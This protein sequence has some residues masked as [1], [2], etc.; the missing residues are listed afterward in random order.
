MFP[1]CYNSHI[2][3]ET[4]SNIRIY[5]FAR[6]HTRTHVFF[7]IHLKYLILL[8][9]RSDKMLVKTKW[10]L[11]IRDSCLKRLTHVTRFLFLSEQTNWRWIRKVIQTQICKSTF[12]SRWHEIERGITRVFCT[13]RKNP[14]NVNYYNCISTCKYTN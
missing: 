14:C 2:S 10:F 11:M 8:L 6:I 3:T 13:F 1:G 5:I 12:Q 9:L 7:R 4:I